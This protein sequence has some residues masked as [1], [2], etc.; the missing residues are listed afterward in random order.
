MGTNYYAVKNRP[1]IDDPIHIGK[2]SIGWMFHFQYQNEYYDNP[3]V[4]WNSYPEVIAWLHEHVV[5]K[6][7][8]VILNEY[9]ELISLDEFIEIVQTK[10]KN[11]KDNPSNF[12]NA[13]DVNGYRFSRGDFS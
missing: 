2:A 9:N 5:E 13:D 6:K 11:D 4:V 8:H 1:T 3:P 10:Q 12:S 7:D